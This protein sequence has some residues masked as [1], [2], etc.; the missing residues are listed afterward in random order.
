[1]RIL[2]AC[3][4]F[5]SINLSR[6][7]ALTAIV[8]PIMLFALLL[9]VQIFTNALPLYKGLRPSSSA[10]YLARLR[11]QRGRWQKGKKVRPPP[12]YMSVPNQK[13]LFFLFTFYIYYIRIFEL[14]QIF[15]LQ[16]FEKF[17]SFNLTIIVYANFLTFSNFQNA[18]PLL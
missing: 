10:M 12:N 2:F 1:M 4:I 15:T 14:F 17:S 11:Q 13:D 18:F 3:R 16:V 6:V 9:T 7:I 8:Y 5:S